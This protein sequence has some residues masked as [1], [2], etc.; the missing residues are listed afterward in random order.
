MA[1]V[2]AKEAIEVPVHRLLGKLLLYGCGQAVE[3]I[4]DVDWRSKGEQ[5]HGG[6]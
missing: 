5:L 3:R 6:G 1:A 4:A 2:A